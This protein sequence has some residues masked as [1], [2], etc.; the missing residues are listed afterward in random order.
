MSFG[1]II[2]FHTALQTS[3]TYPLMYSDVSLQYTVCTLLVA[4]PLSCH[5]D[6]LSSVL[7]M[8]SLLGAPCGQSGLM[9]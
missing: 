1:T 5:G 9:M 2:H 4:Q 8:R 3:M 7:V 6:E